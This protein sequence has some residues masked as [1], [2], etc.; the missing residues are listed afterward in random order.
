MQ[1]LVNILVLAEFVVIV[2]LCLFVWRLY[3]A[4][5][6][7]QNYLV[8][9]RSKLKGFLGLAFLLGIPWILKRFRAKENNP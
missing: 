5:N 7:I 6:Q 9:M 8:A 2:F 1:T 3:Q 4:V